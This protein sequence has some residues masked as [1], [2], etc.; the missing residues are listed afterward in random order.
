MEFRK[1]YLLS[2]FLLL[3]SLASQATNV[4]SLE[5]ALAPKTS[6][7]D[8]VGQLEAYFELGK[9]HLN[10][11]NTE[12]ALEYFLAA[13]ALAKKLNRN[14]TKSEIQYQ[15]GN[16]YIMRQEYQKAVEV[17]SEVVKDISAEGGKSLGDAFYKLA[18]AYQTIGNN[19]L[20]F[21]YHFKS[22]KIRESLD[23]KM[24]IAQSLYQIGGVH[25]FQGNHLKSIEYYEKCLEIAEELGS[26]GFK[27]SSLGAI[28]A[29]FS[30]LGKVEE[31]LKYNLEAFEIAKSVDNKVGLA[32]ITFNL[33]D[34][35]QVLGE[36][37]KALKYIEQSHRLKKELNDRWG[38]IGSTKAIG[39]IYVAKGD[40]K[41]GIN[42][43]RKS[44]NIA[45]SLGAKPRLL[46]V[47][48]SLA[49]NLETGGDY[50]EANQY[51]RKYFSLKDS[52][53]NEQTLQ[54]M[55]DTKLKHEI[56]KREI[57]V[58]KRDTQLSHMYNYLI[59]GGFFFLSLILW[60]LFQKYKTQETNNRLQREKNEKIQQQNDE[61]EQAHLTQL[62]T[63][64]L[65]TNQNNQITE[66]IKKLGLKNEE[67]QRFAYIASHDLKEP[68]R[69]IGSFATLLKR[70]FH[71]KLGEDADEYIDF[72]TTNVSRMYALLHEVLMFSKLDNEEIELEWVDLNEIVTTVQETLRG[73]IMEQN[74]QVASQRLPKLKV[75]FAHMTQLFQ[76]IMSN[77]IKYNDKEHPIVE[78]GHTIGKN[79]EFVFYIKDNGIGIDMEF[80]NR[81]FEIFKRLHG[82]N[83]YE[84]TGVGLAI[85]K[86]IVNQYGGRIWIDSEVGEGA[87]FYFT[88]PSVERMDAEKRE[89]TPFEEVPIA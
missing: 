88:L 58:E 38:Q 43:I 24:G 74:V 8:Y 78:I 53:V 59:W 2:F 57:E 5:Q 69:N 26:A 25:F 15:I 84:G 50:K 7:S 76:N 17:L 73:K 44:L 47:Y 18:Q 72:I 49:E 85:C 87:T 79:D 89:V 4:D 34:D 10:D 55:S 41:K 67:L 62:E 66:Q 23:D 16:T 29:A 70:R 27:L 3:F 33:G 37:E 35:Y 1:V 21:E 82:K 12:K 32:Y 56:E 64:K 30:R 61:L 86:K 42:Y 46:E 83:E 22:L 51:Y 52:L 65:L 14:N 39:E 48:E 75:H 6:G 45:Q 20:A 81:I 71:G 36:Y 19:E 11:D 40:Y 28:G 54:K 9:A 77:S 13:E 31:S 63:N 68:L 60:Q 80:K